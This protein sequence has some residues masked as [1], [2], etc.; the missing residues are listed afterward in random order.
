MAT[1]HYRAVKS[2]GS[3]LSG[4]LEASDRR[5]AA[6]ALRRN[7]ARPLELVV[8]PAM[9]TAKRTKARGKGRQAAAISVGELAVLLEAGLQLDRALSLAVEN[10]ED[11]DVAVHLADILRDVREGAPLSR[12]MA[13]KPELFSPTAVAMAEAG[14]AN[15]RL[16]EALTRLASALEQ[17]AELR[18]LVTSSMIYPIALIVIAVGVV[19]LMLLFVVPQFERMFTSTAQKLPTATLV[20]MTA[21]QILRHYGIA[22]LAVLGGSIFA[23]AI[24]LRQPAVRLARDRVALRLPQLGEL[25]RRIETARFARTLGALIEGEVGLPAALALSQR[26][27]TNQV[28]AAAIGKVTDGVK[29]GGGLTAPLAA[30][31]VLPKLAIGFLRT[32]EE[33]SQLGM[34]LTR[35]ADVLDRDVRTRL[36]R[37]IGI[38]TP[39][40][41]VL[42]GVTVAS[43]I[44]SIMSAILGF[45]DLALSS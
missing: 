7:G 22:I 45:N 38:L 29:E 20:V 24:A 2:D 3:S 31:G 30:S 15:G 9:E 19:L 35:L 39:V 41:T 16:G 37:I 6:A 21:S 1:Y 23:A 43:I 18:R 32:G 14:E 17:E 34:M 13:Q 4:E 27:L 40:I 11:K 8:V 26:T 42:L 33:T 10:V 12:A 44:A 28:L 36:E 25:I 5:D